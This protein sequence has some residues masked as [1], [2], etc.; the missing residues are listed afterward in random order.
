MR[1]TEADSV[2]P[3]VPNNEARQRTPPDPITTFD[4]G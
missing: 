1:P 2:L 4:P 3:I